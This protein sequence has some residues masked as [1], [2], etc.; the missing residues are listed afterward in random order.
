MPEKTVKDIEQ[1][2][3]D[4][5]L[6]TMMGG[7]FPETYGTVAES[8]GQKPHDQID[9]LIQQSSIFNLLSFLMEPAPGINPLERMQEEETI[10]RKIG[11]IPELLMGFGLAMGGGGK[12]KAKSL[13]DD[14]LG[15]AKKAK[16]AQK[17]KP[18]RT[19]FVKSTKY[20]R[21]YISDETFQLQL[22]TP[23][24]FGHPAKPGKPQ[25]HRWSYWNYTGHSAYDK[26]LAEVAGTFQ[27][28][29]ANY[30]LNLERK[31]DPET[32]ADLRK[33]QPSFSGWTNLD[34][35]NF[36]TKKDMMEFIKRASDEFKGGGYKIF[37]EQDYLLKKVQVK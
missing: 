15:M 11:H 4:K 18:K 25:E 33:S 12:K 16:P 19:K 10:M 20:D 6:V 9:S 3:A 14:A 1:Q 31:A 21:E 22:E 35:I 8:T 37:A 7:S 26:P 13:L 36:V 29:R 24:E 30:T 27:I 28:K 32:I 5:A 34:E 2:A 23:A 17:L